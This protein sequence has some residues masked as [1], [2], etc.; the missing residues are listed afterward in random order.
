MTF[1]YREY[2]AYALFLEAWANAA[3]DSDQSASQVSGSRY[4][5]AAY[6]ARVKAAELRYGLR[7]IPGAAILPVTA[8]QCD[9]MFSDCHTTSPLRRYRRLSAKCEFHCFFCNP[10]NLRI[11][12]ALTRRACVPIIVYHRI[13]HRLI[14]EFV[15]CSPVSMQAYDWPVAVG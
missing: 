3:D 7:N 11:A 13:G 14:S 12:D 2:L 8:D 6:A 10:S 5:A 4:R 15:F 9:C 1:L